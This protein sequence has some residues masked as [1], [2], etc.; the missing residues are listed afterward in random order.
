M[1]DLPRNQTDFKREVLWR[2]ND[3]KACT[4]SSPKRIFFMNLSWLTLINLLYFDFCWWDCAD[5]LHECVTDCPCNP[6][7]P[8]GC[9]CEDRNV[10]TMIQ[11][12]LWLSLKINHYQKYQIWDEIYDKCIFIELNVKR[13]NANSFKNIWYSYICI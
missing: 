10:V 9:P 4:A 5:G 6:D 3:Q 2:S 8:L 11:S 13:M 12:Y 1:Q 7:C